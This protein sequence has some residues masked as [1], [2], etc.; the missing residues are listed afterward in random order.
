V[1]QAERLL[2]IAQRLTEDRPD[3]FDVKGPG[4]GDKATEAFMRHLC[5]AAR[6]EFGED[7]AEQEICDTNGFRADYFFPAEATIVEVALGLP[8]PKTEFERDNL[9]AIMAKEAD[10]DIGRLFFISKPGAIKKC[11]QPGGAAISDWLLR[12][13]GIKTVVHELLRSARG[14]S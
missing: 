3:F 11:K 12:N 2:K 4:A 1:G 7:F 5:D 14:G 6:D 9:K 8:K 13:H 10:H